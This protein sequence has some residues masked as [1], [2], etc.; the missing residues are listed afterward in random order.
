MKVKIFD[1]C[2]LSK[3][4]TEINDW[5]KSARKII[6]FIRQS[7]EKSETVISIWYE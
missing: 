4:Q 7:G 2:I 3:L 1:G 5:M 6:K